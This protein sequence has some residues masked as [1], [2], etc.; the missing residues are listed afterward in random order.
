MIFESFKL[1]IVGM[2]F[3]FFFLILLNVLMNLMSAI[4]KKHTLLEEKALHEEQVNPKTDQSQL[5]AVISAA[6]MKFR[7]ENR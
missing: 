5:L 6:V 3:V 7:A 1:I 4:L 2:G